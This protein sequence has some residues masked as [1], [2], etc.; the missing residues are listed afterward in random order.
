MTWTDAP[1]RLLHNKT[2]AGWEAAGRPPKEHRPGQDDVVAVSAP[3][4]EIKRYMLTAPISDVEGD[5]D[6]LPMWPASALGR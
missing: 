6:A 1:A 5:I 4:G 2:V 3:R